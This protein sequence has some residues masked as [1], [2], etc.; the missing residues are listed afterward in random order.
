MFNA[1]GKSG[2]FGQLAAMRNYVQQMNRAMKMPNLS[3]RQDGGID[4]IMEDDE[5]MKEDDEKPDLE[6]VKKAEEFEEE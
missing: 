1:K 3:E 2:V 4:M 6:V 5:S